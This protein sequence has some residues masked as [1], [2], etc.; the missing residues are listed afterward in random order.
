MSLEDF[1]EVEDPATPPSM[2]AN[3][4]LV[5]AVYRLHVAKSSTLIPFDLMG[6]HALTKVETAVLEKQV[7]ALAEA[8]PELSTYDES[9]VP[10]CLALLELCHNQVSSSIQ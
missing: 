1:D 6:G 9:S 8:Y 3:L 4:D 10:F 5:R 2:P 7:A